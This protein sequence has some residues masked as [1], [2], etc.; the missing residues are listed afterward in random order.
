MLNKDDYYKNLAE[1]LGIDR[2]TLK[3][4][5]LRR[6]YRGKPKSDCVAILRELAEQYKSE[7]E[8]RIMED[9]AILV[10][11]NKML[12]ENPAQEGAG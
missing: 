9:S 4:A 2:E 7:V 8:T 6:A 5:V 11:I 1:E 10:C 12:E 3:T